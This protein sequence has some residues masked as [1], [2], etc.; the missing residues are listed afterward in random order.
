MT[1]YHVIEKCHMVSEGIEPPPFDL[2]A[3]I[4]PMWQPSSPVIAGRIM[5]LRGSIGWH[6]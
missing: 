3:S 4:L 6:S 2:G 1:M 5:K